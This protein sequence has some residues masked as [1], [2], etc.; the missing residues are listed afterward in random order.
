MNVV[1]LSHIPLDKYQIHTIAELNG[2]TRDA[3]V[4]TCG[5]RPRRRGDEFVYVP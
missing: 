3:R 5:Q 4:R 2:L 1:Q